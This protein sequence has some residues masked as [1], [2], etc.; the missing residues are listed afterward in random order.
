MRRFSHRSRHEA[1][2]SGFFKIKWFKTLTKIQFEGPGIES[3]KKCGALEWARHLEG[4]NGLGNVHI[5]PP[6]G[7]KEKQISES[8]EEAVSRISLMEFSSGG[9]SN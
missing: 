5:L 7:A 1:Q 4:K 2:E 8:M 9:Y 3:H 6:E